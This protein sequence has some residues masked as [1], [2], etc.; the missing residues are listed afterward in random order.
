ML[1]TVSD[2]IKV[3]QWAAKAYPGTRLKLVVR[4]VRAVG[5]VAE[6]LAI[7]HKNS[8]DVRWQISRD[9]TKIRVTDLLAH[10]TYTTTEM[11]AALRWL[12]LTIAREQ[13]TIS[14][15]AELRGTMPN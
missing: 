11:A 14:D 4:D 13:A 9:A 15:R 3:S 5:R 2:C 6:V 8:R 12:R 1:F 7:Q 10:R